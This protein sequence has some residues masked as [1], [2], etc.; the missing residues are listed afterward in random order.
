[1]NANPPLPENAIRPAEPRRIT[2]VIHALNSG[3]AERTLAGL[4][5]HWAAYGAD[6]TL[7]TLDTVASDAFP[8]HPAIRR[9][10]LGLMRPSRHTAAAVAN[11]VRR[12]WALR[13]AIR[14]AGAPLVA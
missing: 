2:L 8:L 12:L 3:G 11:T 4:A 9:V 10:G 6:V 14:E 5:S 1:M 7:I 13:R